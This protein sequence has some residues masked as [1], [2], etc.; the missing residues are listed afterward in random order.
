MADSIWP[1]IH[2][3]RLALADDLTGLNDQ[4]WHTRSLSS[5]WD[6]HEVLA[7]LL[8]AA[9]MTP[10]KFVPGLARVGFDFHRYMG[11]LV[12]VEG[13]GGPEATLAEFRAVQHRTSSPPAPPTTWLGEA[14]VHGEDI[15]RP[16]GIAHDYPLPA[17][18]RVIGF[19][20][21]LNALLGSKRRLAGIM[22]RAS[23]TD[24][25]LGTGPAVEGPAISLLMVTA[26][27]RAALDDLSGPGVA[28]LRGRP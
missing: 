16:L 15:R 23:D 2:A 6:V 28:V 9:K 1:T 19:Y 27:R 5:G 12:A 3:E 21:K 25:V 24:F 7:H 13:A 20:A 14:F 18:T 4:Q 26:G 22:L 11:T 10:V 17:V 8:A